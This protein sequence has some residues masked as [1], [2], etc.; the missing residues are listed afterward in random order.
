M[1][2]I[3]NPEVERVIDEM[4]DSWLTCSGNKGKKRQHPSRQEYGEIIT[5]AQIW[6]LTVKEIEKA[7]QNGGENK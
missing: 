3:T 7:R 4:Y 2:I 1:P 5:H 6:A